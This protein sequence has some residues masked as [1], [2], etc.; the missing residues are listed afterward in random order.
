LGCESA[1]KWQLS[2]TSTIATVIINQPVKY[3]AENYSDRQQ[4]DKENKITNAHGNLAKGC[5]AVARPPLQFTSTFA[6]LTR[7]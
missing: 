5:I 7:M 2:S 6:A 1:E 3:V 4:L